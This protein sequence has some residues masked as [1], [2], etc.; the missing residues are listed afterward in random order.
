MRVN[1]YIR[2]GGEPGTAEHVLHAF[3]RWP[4]WM[5]ANWEI[6]ALAEWIRSHNDDRPEQERVGLYGLD[7][8]SLWESLSAVVEYLRRVTGAAMGAV[9][10]RRG[11]GNKGGS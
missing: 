3:D 5:W 7:V 9:V 1:Q 6:V 2:G 8:Y 4:T 11:T 10:G